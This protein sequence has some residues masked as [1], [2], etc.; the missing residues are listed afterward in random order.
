MMISRVGSVALCIVIAAGCAGC[1]ASTPFTA[2]PESRAVCD[3]KPP[4]TPTGTPGTDTAGGGVFGTPEDIDEISRVL[5]TEHAEEIASVLILAVTLITQYFVRN[6]ATDIPPGDP[7][8]NANTETV[9]R[10]ET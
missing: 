1:G 7:V 2:N 8:P 4:P 5:T 3:G 6:R 9:T 10:D